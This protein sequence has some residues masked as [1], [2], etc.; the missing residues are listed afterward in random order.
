ML[1]KETLSVSLPRFAFK[2]VG[3]YRSQEGCEKVVL[4]DCDEEVNA[5]DFYKAAAD[6]IACILNENA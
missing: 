3:N 5:S 6:L 1:R 4:N 2:S